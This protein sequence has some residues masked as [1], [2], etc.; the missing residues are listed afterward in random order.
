MWSV[1]WRKR[2][3][4]EED[5]MDGGGQF[6]RAVVEWTTEYCMDFIWENGIVIFDGVNFEKIWVE[7][8]RVEWNLKESGFGSLLLLFFNRRS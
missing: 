6:Q 1:V 7:L 4:E 3:R 2:E 5:L 8:E